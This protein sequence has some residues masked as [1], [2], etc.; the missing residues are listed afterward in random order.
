[1]PGVCPVYARGMPGMGGGGEM[2]KL[3]FD[4]YIISRLGMVFSSFT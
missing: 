2:L 1:M 3:Q 4:W